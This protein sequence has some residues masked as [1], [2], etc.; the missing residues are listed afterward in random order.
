MTTITEDRQ[1][2][3]FDSSSVTLK[4]DEGHEFKGSMDGALHQ[5]GTGVEDRL[6]W[7]QPAVFGTSPR[8]FW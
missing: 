4:W 6:T 5:L 1:R 8:R 2:L 7:L 3:H